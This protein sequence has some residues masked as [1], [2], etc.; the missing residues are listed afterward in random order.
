MSVVTCLPV[1]C[2]YHVALGIMSDSKGAV[3]TCKVDH[4]GDKLGLLHSSFHFPFFGSRYTHIWFSITYLLHNLVY[5]RRTKPRYSHLVLIQQYNCLFSLFV[6]IKNSQL[7]PTSF[8]IMIVQLFLSIFLPLFNW[9]ME[10]RCFL[11]TLQ[12]IFVVSL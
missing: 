12:I 7:G 8:T 10:S 3:T 9:L 4:W 11:F 6:S 1:I 5:Y 2:Q